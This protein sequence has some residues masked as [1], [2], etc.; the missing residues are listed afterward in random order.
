MEQACISFVGITLRK[1]HLDYLDC[2]LSFIFME[3]LFIEIEAIFFS[4]LLY[5]KKMFLCQGFFLLQL[6]AGTPYLYNI[7]I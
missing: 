2:F 4:P 1:V 5:V 3:G 6:G 7:L